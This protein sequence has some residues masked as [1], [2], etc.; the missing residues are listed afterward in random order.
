M[1][2]MTLTIL[3]VAGLVFL[4]LSIMALFERSRGPED[5]L[6]GLAR[7]PYGISMPTALL[8]LTFIFLGLNAG[9]FAPDDP[10]EAEAAKAAAAFDAEF[11]SGGVRQKKG[12]AEHA[13]NELEHDLEHDLAEFDAEFET[14]GD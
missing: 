3:G 11:E 2:W 8:S 7:V 5:E 14:L 9:A 10:I 13:L 4:P 1:M 12:E 6:R